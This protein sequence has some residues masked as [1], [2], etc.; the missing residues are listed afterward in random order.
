MA[1]HAYAALDSYVYGF[2]LQE[3][4]L[5]FRPAEELEE[6]SD[7]ILGR[8]PAG[9]YPHLTEMTVEH[10]L[11]PGYSYSNEFEFGLDLML[12]GLERIRDQA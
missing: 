6:V 12:D 2:A 10:V 5:P 3:S 9:E 4:S 7:A 11:Q 1:A 8:M